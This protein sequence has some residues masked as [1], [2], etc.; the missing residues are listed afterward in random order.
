MPLKVKELKY[1]ELYAIL[2]TNQETNRISS[3]ELT[4][5]I[6]SGI[7][8]DGSKFTVHIQQE[9]E[10][11]MDLIRENVRDFDIVPPK[12][13]WTQV[14]LH[15]GPMIILILFFWFIKIF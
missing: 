3:L 14:L 4:D 1:S 7:F 10:A 9:D 2:L 12:T 8:D 13:F 6:L 5:N 11:I 15:L